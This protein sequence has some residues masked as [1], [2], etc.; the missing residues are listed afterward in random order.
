MCSSLNKDHLP[1]Q[2]LLQYARLFMVLFCRSPLM[3][4]LPHNLFIFPP[5]NVL[6]KAT[7]NAIGRRKKKST[8]N[9]MN[10]IGTRAIKILSHCKHKNRNFIITIT[11]HC[12]LKVYKIDNR[13]KAIVINIMKR[14]WVNCACHFIS[15]IYGSCYHEIEWHSLFYHKDMDDGIQLLLQYIPN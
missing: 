12:T 8:S 4:F 11:A 5:T 13:H 2:S 7:F 15:F 6:Q 1:Y 10:V 9:A 14:M 3:T